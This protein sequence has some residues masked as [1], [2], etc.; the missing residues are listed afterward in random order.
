MT[1]Y[2]INDPTSLDIMR[3]DFDSISEDEWEEYIELAEEKN[4]SFKKIGVLR[5]V[6]RKAGIS[7]FLSDKLIRWA[8]NIIDD[9][10]EMQESE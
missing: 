2:D 5:S 6:K 7:K 1:E 9:L 10:D 3:A 8:L 4:I